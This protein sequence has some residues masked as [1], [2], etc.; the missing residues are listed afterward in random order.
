MQASSSDLT[1]AATQDGGASYPSAD[2]LERV[3]P[4]NSPT[5]QITVGILDSGAGGLTVLQQC[6]V[7]APGARYIYLADDLAFPYGIKDPTAVAQAVARSAALLHARGAELLVIAGDTASALGAEAARRIF[8]KERVL[9]TVSALPQAVAGLPNESRLVLL[10]TPA[11]LRAGIHQQVLANLGF[12]DVLAI[13]SES[14]AAA[15]QRAAIPDELTV[16][17]VREALTPIKKR[18]SDFLLVGC[19]NALLQEDLL[20][21][22]AGQ[23]VRLIDVREILGVATRDYVGDDESMRGRPDL[24]LLSTGRTDELQRYAAE[25]LTLPA[26]VIPA[27]ADTTTSAGIRATVDALATAFSKTDSNALEGLMADNVLLTGCGSA[28]RSLTRQHAA[29]AILR[30]RSNWTDVEVVVHDLN[31]SDKEVVATGFLLGLESEGS[32]SCRDISA[33]IEIVDGHIAQLE[34]QMEVRSD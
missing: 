34:F 14:L 30:N 2:Y 8:G 13:S 24:T 5:K 19:T 3:A 32:P 15:A 28:P 4:S 7:H 29:E 25:R 11:A 23:G 33:S 22:H 6:L 26:I 20:K 21:R 18:N 16:A 31:Q 10:T 17:A 1:R 27:R 9:D 12:K